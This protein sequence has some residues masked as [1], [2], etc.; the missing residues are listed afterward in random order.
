MKMTTK[1]KYAVTTMCALATTFGRD[2]LPRA[3]DLANSQNI[4]E[5]YLEQL[6]NKLKKKGLIRTIRGP[7]GGYSLSR[8]P[9]SIRIADVIE[10]TEGPISLVNCVSSGKCSLSS[11]C[12]PKKFWSRLNNVIQGVLNDTTLADLI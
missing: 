11:N 4:S 12:K 2:V 9:R 10:A 7:N 6:L 5:M 3:K 8:E 1:G